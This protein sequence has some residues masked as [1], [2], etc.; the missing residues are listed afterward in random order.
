TKKRLEKGKSPIQRLVNLLRDGIKLGYALTG[1]NS[2]ELDNK[3]LK[4][5]SPRFLSVTPE[6]GNNDT[7]SGY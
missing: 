3:T 6:D 1:K 7:V 4:V 2:T 5:V